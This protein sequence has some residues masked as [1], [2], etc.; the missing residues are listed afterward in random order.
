MG[1][2][3]EMIQT[4]AVANDIINRAWHWFIGFNVGISEN[5][6]NPASLNQNV[7][8]PCSLTTAIQYTLPA[9]G[10]ITLVLWNV[11]GRTVQQIVNE[12]SAAGTHQVNV[13]TSSLGAGVYYYTLQT[14]SGKL[15]RK[16]VVTK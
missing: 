11:Q 14:A 12:I 6:L 15:T 1:V 16:M 2:G 13:N 8:N 7:P 10:H 3:L 5:S 9:P 4:V